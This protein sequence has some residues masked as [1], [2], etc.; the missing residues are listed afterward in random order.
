M[1]QRDLADSPRPHSKG[2]ARME[3]AQVPVQ[4][5]CDRQ[6]RDPAPPGT[7]EPR[8]T[9]HWA[10]RAV[11][12]QGFNFPTEP[13]RQDRCGRL[14]WPLLHGCK[15]AAQ[16]QTSSPHS[17]QEEGVQGCTTSPEAS[18]VAL[19]SSH[20]GA[21]LPQV[22]GSA[23]QL[24]ELREGAMGSSSLAG[25]QEDPASGPGRPMLQTKPGSVCRGREHGAGDCRH[26]QHLLQTL[27]RPPFLLAPGGGG[28]GPGIQA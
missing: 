3:I 23:S 16:S 17:Q 4:R 18:P 28:S 19:L 20:T 6:N 5:H 9:K 13:A 1:G 22:N 7:L 25:T 21:E 27:H 26:Q 14:S 11:N 2:R 24:G 15:R 8:G 10:G 12:K